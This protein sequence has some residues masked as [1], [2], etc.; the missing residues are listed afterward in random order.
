MLEAQAYR[1]AFWRVS[2]E[3][4]NY[5]RFF[6]INDLVGLRMENPAV[7]AATHRLIRKLLAEEAVTGL[8][9]DHP[10]GLLNPIQYF[11]RLQMLYAASQCSGGEPREPLAE[12]GIEKEIVHRFIDHEADRPNVLRF[13]WLS[14]KYSSP[15]KDCRSTGRWMARLDMTSAIC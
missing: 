13:T 6:D 11:M 14:K 7:F 5:R 4:I 1:L 9:L 15:A 3:E 8:R 12:N 2:S 10:D